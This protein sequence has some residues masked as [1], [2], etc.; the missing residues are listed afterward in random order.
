MSALERG[1]LSESIGHVFLSLVSLPVRNAENGAIPDMRTDAFNVRIEF[2]GE[3]SG[4]L[5]II[6]E[7]PLAYLLTGR[8]LGLSDTQGLDD[9]MIEDA[10]KELANVVCGHFVTLMF[11]YA[12][13]FRILLPRVF[14]IGCIACNALK[15]KEDVCSFTVDGH[16]MMAMVRL[17]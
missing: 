7:R 4:E 1:F 14:S 3:R 12:S 13:V 5:G 8:I 9:A 6:V 10:L 17:R 16:P 11:G 2:T 15:N